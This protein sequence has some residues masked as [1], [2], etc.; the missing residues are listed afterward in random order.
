MPE[1]AGGSKFYWSTIGQQWNE[2]DLP[3]SE[4]SNAIACGPQ[5]CVAVG[6]GRIVV[7]ENLENWQPVAEDDDVIFSDV[8][9]GD[10][11]Y[12]A[13][14]YQR[15]TFSGVVWASDD[16]VH[17]FDQSPTG[18]S[19]LAAVTRGDLVW[20]SVGANGAV[21][22]SPEGQDWTEVW[23]NTP[24][25]I[26]SVCWNGERFIAVGER[27]LMITSEDAREWTVPD[28]PSIGV[29]K[30]NDVAAFRTDVVAIG[31]DGTVLTSSDGIEWQIDDVP[32]GLS[33]NAVGFNGETAVIV[34]ED[35]SVFG[36]ICHPNVRRP[37]GRRP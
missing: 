36:N 19:R 23:A 30:L 32:T 11:R 31:T 3:F 6:E 18:A 7:S 20:V 17:W 14:G 33:L 29:V 34:G 4:N 8:H 9:W 25:T 1:K 21:F 15:D 16:G 5:N 2:I 35:G 28:V 37:S 27:S 10:D 26:L 24:K 13:V 22:W 12:I